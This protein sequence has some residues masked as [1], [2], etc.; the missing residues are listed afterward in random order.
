[1]SH[2]IRKHLGDFVAIL[3]LV[4]IAAAVAAYILSN[5][6]LRFPIVESKPVKLKAELPNAQ[7][8]TP[9][10][11]QTV[12]VAGVKVG[13]IGK[14]DL[15]DGHA[16]VTME[17][18]HK[19]R[20]L[21]HQGATA[22]LRPKTGLKD[23]LLEVDPGSKSAPVMTE[24]DRIPVMN[25]APDVNQDEIFTALDSDTRDYLKLLIN[26]AGKGLKGR[27]H[28]LE[29]TF[30]RLGPIHRD[31]AK[32]ATAVAERRHNLARLVHNYSSLT[33]ELADK[34]QD[35]TRLVDASAAVFR[36]FASEDQNISSAVAK[37]PG[38]LNT[39]SNTLVKVN[40]L[41]QVLGPSLDALRPAIRK[42]DTANKASRPFLKE[43]EPIIRKKIRPFVQVATPYVKNDL[44][45]AAHNLRKATPDLSSVFFELNRFFNMAGFNPKGAESVPGNF[46]E[47]RN[48][49]EGYLFWV[50]W[51]SQ[52]TDSL[53]STADASGPFRRALVGVDCS[54]LKLLGAEDPSDTAS[55]IF[56]TSL[57]QLQAIGLCP[58]TAH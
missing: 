41:G 58:G 35:L 49:D 20:N 40:R 52:L 47:A 45:P 32:V 54:T 53:F 25:S 34:D 8:V 14:V 51:V 16:V 23:M 15:E 5:E 39:T 50:G 21:I 4:V 36:A 29:E 18:D 56:G 28:D 11:G 24:K 3:A 1:M 19:Y 10:Q 7:A 44:K 38:A 27:S 33:N 12:R 31:L 43:A 6:R 48:R 57:T 46:A 9:G 55:L 13:D 26:G 30:R 17:I 2:A 22:L 37:L 42:L